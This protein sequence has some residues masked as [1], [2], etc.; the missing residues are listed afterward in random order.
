MRR[1]ALARAAN[2]PLRGSRRSFFSGQL[3]RVLFIY[4]QFLASLR[5]ADTMTPTQVQGTTAKTQQSHTSNKVKW[6]VMLYI[7]ADSPLAN[8]AIE[9]L[10]QIKRSIKPKTD[11][12]V[13]VQFCIDPPGGQRIPRYV[14]DGR[15]GPDVSV[16]RYACEPLDA[17]C[18][19]TEAE[20]LASFVDWAYSLEKYQGTYHILV[21][22]G[23]GPELLLQTSQRL[24]L[25]PIQL[26][27]ALEQALRPGP[28]PLK[29]ART[30]EISHRH[31]DI[32]GFDAC[33]M[34][35]LEVAYEI[36]DLADF[37]VASQEDVPDLSFPYDTLVLHVDWAKDPTQLAHESPRDYVLA[38]QDYVYAPRTDLKKVTLSAVDLRLLADVTKGLMDLV[39]ALLIAPC[40]IGLADVILASREE[41]QSFAGGLYV[42]LFGFA[43]A[44]FGNLEMCAKIPETDSDAIKKACVAIRNA[45]RVSDPIA[46]KNGCIL[47]NQASDIDRCHGLSLYFPY[48]TDEEMSAIQQPLVKGGLDTH[49]AKGGL[50]THGVKD[51]SDFVNMA[52]VDVLFGFRQQLIADTEGYYGDL[53]LSTFTDWNRFVACLWSCILAERKSGELDIVYS[54]EQ[55]AANL[56]SCH[57]PTLCEEEAEK[58]GKTKSGSNSAGAASASSQS[59][60]RRKKRVIRQ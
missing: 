51:V 24:F 56:R 17:P 59:V 54:A 19:M 60:R 37:M 4:I 55:C 23:H 36:R 46:G 25:T 58:V 20:A 31:L 16:S 57:C 12:I 18:N 27:Q 44:L 13:A 35:M 42:D 52:A 28:R 3:S 14:F 45:L 48:L 9:S 2:M 49:G 10:K 47:A 39:A 5:L 30:G 6:L 40:S 11:V 7:S 34:A 26:R 29:A 8:F 21:L 33:S 41:A 1:A 43:D 53:S 50:D 15:Y 22:W 38:Y 32:I